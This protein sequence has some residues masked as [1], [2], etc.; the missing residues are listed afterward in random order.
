ME[1]GRE[2][3]RGWGEIVGDQGKKRRGRDGKGRRERRRH[4]GRE[5]GDTYF[6]LVCLN[7][8]KTEGLRYILLT[9]GKRSI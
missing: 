3:W 2:G 9:E 4:G 1:G 6:F 7:V 5:R 8:H